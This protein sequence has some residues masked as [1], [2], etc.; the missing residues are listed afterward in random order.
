M[1]AEPDVIHFRKPVSSDGYHIHQLVA[2]SPPLDLNSAYSYYLMCHHFSDSCVIAECQG[3]II[4][5]ISAYH[6]PQHPK[7]LFVWQVVVNQANRGNQ[8]AWRMLNSLLKRFNNE[9]LHILE[10]TVNPSNFASRA[11]FERLATELGTTIEE[12]VFLEASA[13]GSNDNHESEI[14]LRIPLN[15]R[16]LNF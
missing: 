9:R 10:V 7:K 8:I 4:G 12:E 15:S 1:P 5:F 6:M 11:L 3:N 13:F 16:T 2:Q 14:L